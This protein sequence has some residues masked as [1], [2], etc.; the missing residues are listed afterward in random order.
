MDRWEYRLEVVTGPRP[1]VARGRVE[2]DWITE[3]LNQLGADGWE[4]IAVRWQDDK[5]DGILKRRAN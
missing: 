2:P 1:F 5:W 3:R 4:L